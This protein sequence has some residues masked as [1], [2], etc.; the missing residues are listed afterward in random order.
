MLFETYNSLVKYRGLVLSLSI[1]VATA[2]FLPSYLVSP[3][4]A[5]GFTGTGLVCITASTTAINCPNSPPTIGPVTLGSTFTVGVFI[6]NSAAMGGYVIYVAANPAFLIP[7]RATLGTLITTPSLT[8]IC[9]NASAQNGTCT[10]GA[11][12]GPGAVEVSTVESSGTNECGGL[13]PCS[14]MAFTITYTVVG[15]TPS[16]SLYFPTAGGCSISSVSSPPNTCVLVDTSIGTPLPETVQGATVTSAAVVCITSPAKAAPCSVGPAKIPVT[17]GSTFTVGVRVE[18]SQPL[19]GFDI[20]VS[21]DRN[22]LN[23]TSAALGPLILNPSLTTR[24]INGQSVEGACTTGT[25]NGP[26]VVEVST[27]E[28]SGSNECATTPCSGLA[29][30]ITYQ[31]VGATPTTLISYPS[32]PGCSTSSVSSP[33]NT[34]VLVDNATGTTLPHSIQGAV[35]TQ[36]VTTGHSTILSATCSS[37]VVV[38]EP[39]TCTANVTDISSGAVP[40][41]GT[42]AWSTDAAGGFT[43]NFCTLFSVGPNTSKCSVHYMPSLVGTGGPAGSGITHIGAAYSGDTIHTG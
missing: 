37:P 19:A 29:F 38:G 25:A 34:C 11:A 28:G 20:Y 1:L 43:L 8:D 33:L 24:C 16:T 12:N 2:L 35:V 27:V 22:Y 6:N 18:N 26:G 39:T 42:V 10:A 4:R 3:A 30:N 36:S 21:V 32:A 14:G 9:V 31:V 40:P 7:I 15:S 17:L 41:I 23:P 13:S 5:V